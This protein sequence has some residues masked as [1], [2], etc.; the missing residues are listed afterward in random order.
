MLTSF[1]KWSIVQTYFLS[2]G[3]ITSLFVNELLTIFPKRRD[4]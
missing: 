1:K 2:L 3:N 4:Y